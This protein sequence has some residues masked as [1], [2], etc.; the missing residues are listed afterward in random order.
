MV[1]EVRE[2]L[3]ASHEC[4]LYRVDEVKQELF[5]AASSGYEEA[6]LVPPKG[7]I[8]DQW[9]MK[10]SQGLVVEDTRSDYRFHAD[11]RSGP[12]VRRSVCASPLLSE[13][14]VLG[15]VRLSAAPPGVFHADDLRLLDIFAGIGAVNLRNMLLYQKMR[16]LAV[17]DSLSKLYVNR[18]FMEQ[19]ASE[20]QKAGFSK[21]RLSV[22]LL[23][24]DF[25]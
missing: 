8:Y 18:Y 10:K 6:S 22:I 5:F 11:L 2:S 21:S 13:N 3:G 23:D 15:V 17:R 1:Q 25:F 19:T 12:D 16:E 4:V 7:N 14:R 20:I 9:V 24:I